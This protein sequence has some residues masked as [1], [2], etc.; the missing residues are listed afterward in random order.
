MVP[1]FNFGGILPKILFH[2]LPE[3]YPMGSLCARFQFMVLEMIH[4][5]FRNL[6]R[7]ESWSAWTKPTKA[8][9]GLGTI[10][11]R[12]QEPVRCLPASVRLQ[13]L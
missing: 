10:E 3:Y 5:Y 6:G 7:S 12:T 4:E 9:L 13:N 2:H 8:P 1:S 11:N